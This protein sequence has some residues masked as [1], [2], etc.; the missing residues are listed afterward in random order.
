ML[1]VAKCGGP[2]IEFHPGRTDSAVFDAPER[3]P[4]PTE[5]LHHTVGV[6]CPWGL[7][8]CLWQAALVAQHAWPVWSAHKT[9]RPRDCLVCCL[10]P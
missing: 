10:T 6:E 3:L 9:G 2:H 1:A 4:A 7:C 8:A 5:P